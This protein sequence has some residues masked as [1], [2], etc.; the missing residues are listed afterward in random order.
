MR[1]PRRQIAQFMQ[2]ALHRVER[3]AFAGQNAEFHQFV[4]W[5][6]QVAVAVHL[7]HLPAAVQPADHHAV[8]GQCAGLV[9]AQHGGGAERFDTAPPRA[10][11]E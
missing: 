10:V 8:F 2:R 7:Q 4:P 3:H 9:G 1:R 5:F 6:G 11:R